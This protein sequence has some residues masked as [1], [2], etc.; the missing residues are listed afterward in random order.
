MKVVRALAAA[1][2]ALAI[3]AAVQIATS[4]PAS[5]EDGTDCVVCW[6]WQI[7]GE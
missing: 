5:A 4:S 7:N 1:A 3:G 6:W 2:T